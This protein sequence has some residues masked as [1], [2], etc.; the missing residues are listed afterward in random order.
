MVT[1][2]GTRR[3]YQ[4]LSLQDRDGLTIIS[5]GLSEWRAHTEH[6][7]RKYILETGDQ[8]QNCV[9]RILYVGLLG[10]QLWRNEPWHSS[11]KISRLRDA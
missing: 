4:C 2:K 8:E 6:N 7:P 11:A 5:H 1:T 10:I 9:F 3:L